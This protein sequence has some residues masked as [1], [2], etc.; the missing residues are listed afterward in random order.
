LSRQERRKRFIAEKSALIDHNLFES[1]ELARAQR[2][3]KDLEDELELVKAA[4]AIVQWRGADYPKRKFQ[5]AQALSSLGY[6]E[7]ALEIDPKII[8]V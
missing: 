7:P 2:T 1:D 6:R 5:V 8:P 3:I 4:A